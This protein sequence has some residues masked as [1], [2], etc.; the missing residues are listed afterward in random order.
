MAQNIKSVK[1][2]DGSMLN[3]AISEGK[4]LINLQARNLGSEIKFTSA[5]VELNHEDTVD[6]VNWIGDRLMEGLNG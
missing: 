6:L 5:S 3:V 4:L 1:F 2:E